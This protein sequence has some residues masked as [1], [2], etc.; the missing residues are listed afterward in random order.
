MLKGKTLR[1]LGLAL[2]ISLTA[3]VMTAAEANKRPATK[4]VQPGKNGKYINKQSSTRPSVQARVRAQNRAAKTAE[5]QRRANNKA[6]ALNKELYPRGIPKVAVKR[7][8]LKSALKKTTMD[9]R[10]QARGKPVIG[11]A[12]YNNVR[13][14]PN[15][16][17]NAAAAQ[18]KP[19]L[20]SRFFGFFSRRN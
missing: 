11:F 5:S 16:E 8:P 1:L 20:L 3:P 10:Q 15:R 17:Q 7:P 18:K 14:I 13:T 9:T 12:K 2:T 19:G 4:N 6:R